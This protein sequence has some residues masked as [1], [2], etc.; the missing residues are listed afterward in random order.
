MSTALDLRGAQR[1]FWGATEAQSLY[2]GGTLLW[3]KPAPP[4]GLRADTQAFVA[5][6][7]ELGG[8]DIAGAQATALN[9]FFTTAAASTWWPKI[10]TLYSRF[11]DSIAS[12]VDL[13]GQS[14][15]AAQAG[16]GG[17]LPWS[18]EFGWSA[19]ANNQGLDLNINPSAVSTQ[20][21]ASL[22]LWYGRLPT[23]V[24]GEISDQIG[25]SG[26]V[27]GRFINDGA[28]RVR[29]HNGGNINFNTGHM[30][31]GFRA[32]SRTATNSLLIYG[33]AGQQIGS[34]TVSAVTPVATSLYL[35]PPGGEGL[36]SDAG[37]FAVGFG[38]G[39]TGA[40]ILALR[41]AMSDLIV[42]F[43]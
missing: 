8:T 42:A 19:D 17:N 13:K 32:A 29:L 9:A 22:I 11:S 39:L 3:T 20:A 25:N 12:R 16:T 26:G 4:G 10:D 7:A 43:A 40:E 36:T 41:N 1:L 30:V 6:V 23:G 33:A 5:R 35:G 34:S 38:Q 21:S 24:Q 18:R 14:K 2:Y 37:V 31:T 28:V 27:Y 15:I